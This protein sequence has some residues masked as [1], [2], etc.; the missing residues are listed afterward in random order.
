[1]ATINSV[2]GPLDTCDLGFTLAH[3]HVLESSAGIQ[4]VYPEFINREST[5]KKAID[6]FKQAYAEG[7]RTIVDVTTMD[8][9]RDVRLL[10]QVSRESEVQII[11]ATGVWLDIPRAFWNETP[12]TISPLFIREI[13]DG[14]EGTGIKAGIIKVANGEE[15][16]TAQGEVILRAAAW[17]HKETGVPISTHTWAAGRVGEAQLRVFEEEGVNLDRVYIGHSDNTD[18]VDYLK[19]LLN[20][21]AWVGLD[22]LIAQG[23]RP[24]T[25]DFDQRISILGTLINAGFASQ[26]MLSQD[27]SV[28]GDTFGGKKARAELE[29]QNPDGYL[30]ITRQVLPRLKEMGIGE[31]TVR[32]LMVENPKRFFEGA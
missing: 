14:I 8:L 15:G 27:W 9:G 3:E 18:D 25:P 19:G 28:M 12:D 26:I 22:R 20:K 16:V 11:C 5:I 1:M 2:L 30:T 17:A 4:H 6:V 23:H 7:V 10:Q 32:Q 31:E 29:N 21:G 24:G 13:R